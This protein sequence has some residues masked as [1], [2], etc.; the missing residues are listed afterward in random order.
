MSAV[1]PASG[2]VTEGTSVRLRPGCTW[3][4]GPYWCQFRVGTFAAVCPYI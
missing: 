2:C 1:G 4:S 3:Q